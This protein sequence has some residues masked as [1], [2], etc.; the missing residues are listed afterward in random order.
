MDLSQGLYVTAMGMGL[1][2]LSLAVLLFAVKALDRIFPARAEAA[3]EPSSSL[4]APSE[5][6]LAP[7]PT[8]PPTAAPARPAASAGEFAA[9]ISGKRHAVALGGQANGSRQVVVDGTPHEVKVD[10]SQSG[11]IVIDG[12]AYRAEVLEVQVGRV[13]V[14]VEG[15][16]FEVELPEAA[17]PAAAASPAPANG[18]AAGEGEPVLAPLPGKVLRIVVAPGA[19]V[20]RGQELC[21]LEAMKME[22]SIRANRQGVVREVRATEGQSVAAGEPLIILA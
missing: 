10:A 7:E 3:N 22:N 18:A 2:F 15:S 12:R 17:A 5:A 11:G 13:R 14:R 19:R 9:A 20:E 1:V 8:A 4:A 21:V 6:P 16:T